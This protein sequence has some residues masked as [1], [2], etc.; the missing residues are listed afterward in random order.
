MGRQ[1]WDPKLH[2][3]P[4]LSLWHQLHNVYST[5]TDHPCISYRRYKEL[6]SVLQ[7]WYIMILTKAE[8]VYLHLLPCRFKFICHIFS[9]SS[10]QLLPRLARIGSVTVG[11]PVFALARWS[12]CGLE[13][14]LFPWWATAQTPRP[15]VLISTK[16]SALS[17]SC[18]AIYTQSFLKESCEIKIYCCQLSNVAVKVKLNIIV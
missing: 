14:G 11:Q 2:L 4:E 10:R 6:S 7:T 17:Y 9:Q 12:H 3:G 15:A 13:R 18:R 16:P 8:F 5:V 1:L